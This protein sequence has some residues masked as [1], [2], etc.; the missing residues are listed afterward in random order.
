[1]SCISKGILCYLPQIMTC[2]RIP[3]FKN[4]DHSLGGKIWKPAHPVTSIARKDLRRQHSS[5]LHVSFKMTQISN[6]N[7]RLPGL[8]EQESTR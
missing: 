7:V 2:C 8:T 5:D 3:N 4:Q 6:L 1:M